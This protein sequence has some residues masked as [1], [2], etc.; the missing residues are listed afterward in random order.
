MRFEFATATR[1]IFG[2]GTLKEVGAIAAKMGSRALIVTGSSALRQAPG[3]PDRARPLLDDLTAQG[4]E[5]VT[6]VV[7]GEPTTHLVSEGTREAREADCDLVIGIGG[8]SVIDTGKA[9]AALL[10]NGGEPLDYLEVIGQGQP[11]TKPPAPY[12]AIPTTA[13]TGSEVT[14]NAVLASPEH[15]VKVSLRSNLTLPR[16]AVVD[17][18]LTYSMPPALTASTGLDALT[19]VIEPYVSNK[20][21]PLTDAI[22]REGIRRGALSLRRAYEK[23]SD[24]VAREDMAITSLFGGLALANAKLGAVHGFAGPMG[25]MFH[26]PHGAICGQLLPHVMAVNVQALQKRGQGG[27]ALR[28]YDE[29]AQLLIGTPRATA[30]DGVSWMQALCAALDVPPLSA[31]GVTEGD[32]PLIIEKAAKSSSMKGNPV[33]LTVEEMEEILKRAL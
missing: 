28:R 7:P 22:C 5:S 27:D 11:L 25:G 12:I 2:A 9:I 19:Q 3:K 30:H 32:F 4:V 15:R 23:G 20:A 1:I 16:L 17:P 24:A 33:K 8:G 21:N 31:H 13:G 10:T 18:E 14:K 26:A 29:V 6:F